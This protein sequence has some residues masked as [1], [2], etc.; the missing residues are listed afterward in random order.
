[1]PEQPPTT[2]DEDTDALQASI[3]QSFQEFEVS[4]R[5]RYPLIWLLSVI[6]PPALTATILGLL[7][8]TQGGE[9]VRSLCVAGLMTFFGLGRF[10]IPTLPQLD[11]LNVT[12][13]HAFL[14]V[15]YMDLMVALIIPFHIGILFRI[16]GIG[17]KVSALVADGQFVLASHPWMK[18]ASFL[19]LVM[20]VM[21]PLAATGSVGGA[22]FSRLLGMSRLASVLGIITGGLIGNGIMYLF[23]DLFAKHIGEGHPILRYSGLAVIVAI[24]I[25]LERRYRRAKQR[26]L[27]DMQQRQRQRKSVETGSGQAPST[28]SHD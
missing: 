1:M 26:F 11:W 27:D 6:I 13:E 9:Y 23:A 19:G 10:A 21:F 12:K 25:V 18:R 15:S 7:A 2:N 5:H 4:F 22:I 20:F 8:V 16:P 17:P 14:L 3:L 24:I 28:G